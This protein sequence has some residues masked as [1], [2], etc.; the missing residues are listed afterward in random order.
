MG[1]LVPQP[2]VVRGSK[3]G[4]EGDRGASAAATMEGALTGQEGVRT[5][6]AA[7]LWQRR[8]GFNLNAAAGQDEL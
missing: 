4:E 5:K 6:F 8:P 1:E 7:R 3:K 2:R